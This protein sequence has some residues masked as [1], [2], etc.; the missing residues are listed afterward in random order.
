MGILNATPDSF[1][2]GGEHYSHG[3]V[4]VAVEHA[5]AMARDGADIIDIGG[6]STRQGRASEGLLLLLLLLLLVA[7]AVVVIDRYCCFVLMAVATAAIFEF[8]DL[9]ITWHVSHR[10]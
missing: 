5:L 3:A 6:E 9:L 1:S 4:D 8:S 7:V 2:D 10:T